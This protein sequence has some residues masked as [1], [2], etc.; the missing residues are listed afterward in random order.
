MEV[1]RMEPILMRADGFDGFAETGW[2]YQLTL[3]RKL[4]DT[5]HYH[6]YYEIICII[7]GGCT[8]V[9]NGAQHEYRTGELTILSPGDIHYFSAQ[10]PNTSLVSISLFPIHAQPFFEAFEIEP[11]PNRSVVLTHDELSET[12]RICNRIMLLQTDMRCCIPMCRILLGKLFLQLSEH[13]LSS[14]SQPSGDNGCPLTFVEALQK[15]TAPEYAAEGVSA[16]MRLSKFSRPQ[17]CRLTKKY[18]GKTPHE[19]ITEIRMKY[20]KELILNSSIDCET[21]SETVGFSSYSHFCSVYRK[22]YDKSPSET[23]K[24]AMLLPKNV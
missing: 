18:C 14:G 3:G 11:N 9:I 22:T 20:A 19:I 13:K 24:E 21:I 23:R 1:N 15:I 12:E 4:L 10:L 17:L 6:D 5:P 16:L 2:Y 7:S 8:H